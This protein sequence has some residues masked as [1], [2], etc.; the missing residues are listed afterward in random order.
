MSVFIGPR[1]LLNNMVTFCSFVIAWCTLIG[2]LFC[3]KTTSLVGLPTIFLTKCIRG[4]FIS[5]LSRITLCYRLGH[6]VLFG[7]LGGHKPCQTPQNSCMSM[8]L[9]NGQFHTLPASPW[10]PSP[11]PPPPRPGHP[12]AL[13]H[14]LKKLK[15][16]HVVQRGNGEAQ[17]PLGSHKMW[18]KKAAKTR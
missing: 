18:S 2:Q 1:I 7:G 8:S 13:K 14:R 5:F 15:T 16:A 11:A 6:P 10:R 4:S 17:S 12:L 9:D 3:K